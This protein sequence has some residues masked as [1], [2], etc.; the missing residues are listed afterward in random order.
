VAQDV[1]SSPRH[2]DAVRPVRRLI[3]RVR[4]VEL[5]PRSNPLPR[6]ILTPTLVTYVAMVSVLGVVVAT[7]TVRTHGVDPWTLIAGSLAT[8][9]MALFTVRS[10]TQT[11]FVWNPSVFVNLGLSVTF[12]PIGAGSAALAEAIGVALRTRN[13]LFRTVFNIFNHFL[14]NVSAFWAFSAIAGHNTV[15]LDAPGTFLAAGLAAGVAQHVANHALLAGVIRAS[16]PAMNLRE[17][18]R[19]SLGVLPYS[20][21]Y[22]FAAFTFVVMHYYFHVAGFMALLAPMILLQGYLVRYG[23]RVEAHEKERAAHQK[24]R[25]GLLQQLVEASEMERR[26]IAR[27]LHDGVVQNLAGMAFAL[28]AE[29]SQLKAQTTG[30][31]GKDDLLKLL[32][33]SADETR[34]A[35][36]DLR[37]LIIQLAPPTLRREGLQ[38][39]LLEVLR[40]IRKKGTK[41][42][43]DLPPDLRLREDRAALIFRV[44]QEI[45]RNVA[46]HAEAKN[47]V[48]ELVTE[49]RSAILS[50]QDDGKGF[51]ERDVERRRAE[52]HLGTKAIV[53]LAEEAGGTLTVDSEP[54]RGTLVVLTLPIE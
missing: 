3:A 21:G 18:V 31:L 35:M 24:E 40:D 8:F 32:D 4:A 50:I 53:E 23:R 54:G 42:K 25:E 52:G 20:I 36:K 12:G 37:T 44:A 38:A 34:R 7:L 9:L 26:R 14:S 41:T 28:S 39:A 1:A 43:L 11:T 6:I 19:N 29:S 51:S 2:V 33:D 46:A 10:Q 49:E 47:V 30:D 22:G 13:G 5:L 48:V 45:L 15:P 16:N 27:D 17:V